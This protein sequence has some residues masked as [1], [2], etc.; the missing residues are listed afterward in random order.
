MSLR[1]GTTLVDD[2]SIDRHSHSQCRSIES[3]VSVAYLSKFWGICSHSSAL[4]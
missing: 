4:S 2:I 1:N 3:T